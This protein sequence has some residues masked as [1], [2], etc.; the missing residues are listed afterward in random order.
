MKYDNK[1]PNLLEGEPWFLIRGRDVFAVDSLREYSKLAA[2]KS[3][4]HP[5][6]SPESIS[7]MRHA[8]QILKVAER[9]M[10]WQEA[11]PDKVRE[12]KPEPKGDPHGKAE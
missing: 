2:E 10:D 7:L 8:L 4:K 12:P 3:S 6:K 11:N 9:F 5:P 1:K